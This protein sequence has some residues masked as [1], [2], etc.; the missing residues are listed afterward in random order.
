MIKHVHQGSAFPDLRDRLPQHGADTGRDPDN[1]ILSTDV[2]LVILD[3]S[4]KDAKG[5]YVSGLMAETF[6]VY[7]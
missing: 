5:G 3:V 1:F 4:V 6:R 2:E 7:D